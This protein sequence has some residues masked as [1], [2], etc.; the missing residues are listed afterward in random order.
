MKPKAPPAELPM[1]SALLILVCQRKIQ[2]PTM[3][4]A[5]QITPPASKEADRL[6]RKSFRVTVEVDSSLKLLIKKA[7]GHPF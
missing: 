6:A 1:A 2:L 3:R 7:A 4:L 5:P